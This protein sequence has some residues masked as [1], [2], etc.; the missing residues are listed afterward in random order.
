MK[1][2]LEVKHTPTPWDFHGVF[3][4]GDREKLELTHSPIVADIAGSFTLD[5]ETKKANGEF[6]VRAVNGYEKAIKGLAYIAAGMPDSS[7]KD[8]FAHAQFYAADLLAT[9]EGK[10]E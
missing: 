1:T 10:V 9:I 5:D 3:V 8:K 6:I 4:Y 2:K 7:E